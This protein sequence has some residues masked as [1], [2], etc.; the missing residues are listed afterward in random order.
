MWQESVI[1]KCR[2]AL[3]FTCQLIDVTDAQSTVYYDASQQGNGQLIN[4]SSAPVCHF[5]YYS[6]EGT[7]KNFNCSLRRF[8]A[9]PF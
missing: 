4:E 7:S 8:P 2:F 5:T 6:P 1:D 3:S 9:G